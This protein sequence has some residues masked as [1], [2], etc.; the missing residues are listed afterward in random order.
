MKRIFSTNYSAAAFNIAMLILRVSTGL[1][2]IAKHGLDKLQ[3][4]SKYEP[5]FYNFLGIGSQLS[6]ILVIFAETFCALL[7]VLGLF[8]RLAVIPIIFM[9]LVAAF[10]AKASQ[11]L[12]S[13]EIDFLY[14]IP[15]FV[16]LI[17]GPGRI[18][19]D[20]MMGK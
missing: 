17:I 20:G 14:L 5:H 1:W 2:L 11:P 6:L 19:V 4:F 10:S 3:N 13:K 7:V 15:F 8:T 9:L 16:L 18:S 12:I